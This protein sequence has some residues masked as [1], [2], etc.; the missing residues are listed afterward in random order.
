MEKATDIETLREVAA[1]YQREADKW[2]DS[3]DCAQVA[4]AIERVIAALAEVE[5]LRGLL[6]ALLD[7]ARKIQ[8]WHDTYRDGSGMVVS[9]EA[10]RALW[11]E[12]ARID[13]AL[14]GEGE[15]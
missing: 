5:A 3:Q 15:P 10:V 14:G 11:S 12:V 4:A 1:K 7:A 6:R 8:H 9:A 13:A 2:S